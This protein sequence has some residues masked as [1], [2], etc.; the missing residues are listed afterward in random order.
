MTCSVQS[1][2]AG[3]YSCTTAG[4]APNSR[5]IQLHYSWYSAQQQGHTAALQL[6]QRPTAG[7][8][9]CTSALTSPSRST[10]Q[11]TLRSPGPMYLLTPRKCAIFGVCCEGI[12]KQVKFLVDEAVNVSKGSIGAICYLH[13]FFL[14]YR[15]GEKRVQLHCDN[16]SLQNKNNFVLWHFAWR[17]M[18]GLHSE[19]TINFMPAGLTKFSPDWCFG[20][21]KRAF[22]RSEVSCLDDLC[23]VVEESTARSKINIPQLVGKDDGYVTVNTYDWQGFLSTAFK[24]IPGIL[25]FS[26][27]CL[28]AA[29]L[30]TLYYILCPR[31]GN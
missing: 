8:Y 11:A 2:T 3:T 28:A 20:L 6:V 23:E 22:R 14:N 12:P 18:K 30:G 29:Q 15:L 13:F 16:C 19:V 25:Q 31:P 4:T 26:H 1:P 27:F 5:D 21:L 17:V 7:T 9:S 10:S 24:M